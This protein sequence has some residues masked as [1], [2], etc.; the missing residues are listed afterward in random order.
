MK[1]LHLKKDAYFIIFIFVIVVLSISGFIYAFLKFEPAKE[2]FVLSDEKIS[3]QIDESKDY[4]FKIKNNCSKKEIN[5]SIETFLESEDLLVND[6]NLNS[7]PATVKTIN[8]SLSSHIIK[9]DVLNKGEEKTYMI[10]LV[11][12][13]ALYEGKIVVI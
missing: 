10:K 8:E 5:I 13:N 12:G 6:Q 1:K 9:N 3:L 7:Y 4:T 11:N 2:C